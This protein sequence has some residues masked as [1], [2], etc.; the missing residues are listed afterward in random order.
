MNELSIHDNNWPESIEYKNL[1]ELVAILDLS[2]GRV[3]CVQPADRKLF[4]G[5]C[6]GTISAG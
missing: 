4:R 2:A 5:V 3:R 1:D 6:R